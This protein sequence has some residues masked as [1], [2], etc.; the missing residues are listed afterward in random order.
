MSAPPEAQA[1]TA[2][3]YTSALLVERQYSQQL[4]PMLSSG[5]SQFGAAVMTA[6]EASLFASSVIQVS[7][8]DSNKVRQLASQTQRARAISENNASST[9]LTSPKFM[10]WALVG[11]IAACYVVSR[12][13]WTIGLLLRKFSSF[14]LP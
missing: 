13:D 3:V 12:T 2:D 6:V 7:W 11:M 8:V 4:F 14:M 9:L 5:A 10:Q 1:P